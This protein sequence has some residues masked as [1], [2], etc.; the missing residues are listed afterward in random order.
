[1]NVLLEVAERISKGDYR[2]SLDTSSTDEIGRLSRAMN[3]MSGD[4]GREQAR[5]EN[6]VRATDAALREAQRVAHIGSWEW[7]ISADIVS[8]SAELFRLWQIPPVAAGLPYADFLKHVLPDDRWKLEEAVEAVRNTRKS[9]S[10]DYRVE[11]PSGSERWFCSQ[12][13]CG[14]DASGVAVRLMGTT[15]DITDRKHVEERMSHLAQHD[16]LTNLPNRPLLIDRLRQAIAH[17]HR[18]NS[19]GALLFMDLDHFKEL[20]DSRGHGAGDLILVAVAERLTDVLRGIDTVSRS[21]GDEF[22]IVLTE[23]ASPDAA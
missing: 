12:G 13:R 3:S 19:H 16:P 11:L 6:A 5:A 9:F 15:L 23:L 7:D 22:L 10:V 21:G 17:A 4:I 14:R 20:N 1:L 18:N 2:A 8:C